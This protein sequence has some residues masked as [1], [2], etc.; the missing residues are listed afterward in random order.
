MTPA[1][2]TRGRTA[3]GRLRAL[4]AWL[5]HAERALLLRDDGPYRAAAFVDLGV[6]DAP[7]TTLEAAAALREVRPDLPVIGVDH[8]AARIAA[9]RVASDGAVDFRVG[10]FDL[11]LAPG[12]TVRAIRLMNV[13]RAWRPADIPAV[14]AALGARLLDGG[15]LIEGTSDPAGGVLAAHLLRRRGDDVV[16][17][18]L[19]LHTDFRQ[20]FAPLLFRDRLPKDLRRV[21]P[22]TEMFAFF[23]DWTEAW[24]A[25]RGGPPAE[26]FARSIE[27]LAARRPGVDADPW[28]AANGFL[29][30][31]PPGGVAPGPG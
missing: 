28:L 22:G 5:R 20:G 4:D 16:R 26:A 21:A 23:R 18:G 11:P 9:A 19:L 30:W 17:E 7:D 6:G 14:H 13:L 31:R 29:V 2:P 24:Q 27:G 25:V 12:E 15:L 8:D 10:G 1:P 3:P